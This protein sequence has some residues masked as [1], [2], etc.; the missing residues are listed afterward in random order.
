MT[1]KK[2]SKYI[3]TEFGLFPASYFFSSALARKTADE[4]TKSS[5]SLISAE[6]VKSKMYEIISSQSQD[7]KKLSDNELTK[8]LNQEGIKIARRTVAK[9]R[10]QL[11]LQ[12]SF[13]R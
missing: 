4:N 5:A 7:D 3:Q 1:A 10:A 6:A 13:R 8:L 12:N 2:N 11:G 9:Y